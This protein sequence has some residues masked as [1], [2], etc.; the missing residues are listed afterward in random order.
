MLSAEHRSLYCRRRTERA[1]RGGEE[2]VL[3]GSD[4]PRR[5]W[6]SWRR[7]LGLLWPDHPTRWSDVL[8]RLRPHLVQVFRLTAAAVLTFL[9]TSRLTNGLIDL[10]GPLT[11][12]LVIQAS[13]FS[14][15]KMGAVRVG[16]VLGGVLVATLLSTW[17]GLTWW[18]LGAAIAASL[19]LGKLLRLGEQLLET[20]ISAMLILGVTNHDVAAETRVLN[21][22]IGAGRG[23][24]VQPG[25]PAG[26]ADAVGEPGRG[27]GRRSRWPP[28]WTRPAT[29]SRRARC[30]TARSRTGWARPGPRTPGWSGPG[31]PSPRSRTAV[32]ST[33]GR[34]A[35]PTSSR[36][37]PAACG[38][39]R[40]ACSP[41]GRCWP[42]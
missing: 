21:T 42:R 29:R 16:A 12:L 37:W 7:V 4:R 15:L 35:P 39:R 1:A 10:T 31:P 6:F 11:A 13:A 36:C 27:G 28:R 5:R 24:R 17:V 33:R 18:S 41:S 30:S 23:H 19:L 26:D 32:D 2:A 9:I 40:P 38:P 3:A 8:P 25:L 14:T 20:P 22:L 34:W